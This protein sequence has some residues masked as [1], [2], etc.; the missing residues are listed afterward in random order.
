MRMRGSMS[1][2]LFKEENI[3]D[4]GSISSPENFLFELTNIIEK[5]R[6]QGKTVKINFS[7]NVFTYDDLRSILS[8]LKGYKTEIELVFAE[9]K[10]T[11]LAAIEA[12]LTISGQRYKPEI[13]S[14][15]E[16]QPEENDEEKQLESVFAGEEP[17][18]EEK[19][20]LYV[21]QTLRS[22]QKLE[23]EGNL[24][25]IGDCNAGSEIIAT[26][27]IVVWGILSGIAHAGSKGDTKACIRA[28]KINA[29]QLRIA[30]LLARKPDM[31]EIDR[32]EKSDYF[33]PEEAKISEGEIVIY[34]LHQAYD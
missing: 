12:G 28:F 4:L 26:G 32:S 13:I 17:E 34:S 27:D 9:S 23:H 3:I 25:I 21:K 33:N 7:D 18:K 15:E 20:T 30:D 6:L 14:E 19:H 8:V 22:G 11:K 1:E 5:N 29:I 10:D 16:R 24:I 2:V 31:I